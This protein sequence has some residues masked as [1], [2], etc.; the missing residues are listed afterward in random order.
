MHSGIAQERHGHPPIP[1]QPLGGSRHQQRHPGQHN[2]NDDAPADQL[3]GIVLEPGAPQQ[4]EQRSARH[5]GKVAYVVGG[6]LGWASQ[7]E[8]H[9]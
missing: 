7:G 1:C 9:S 3:G 8:I 5:Q 6:T 4:L 2:E